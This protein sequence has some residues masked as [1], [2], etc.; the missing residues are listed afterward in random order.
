MHVENPF[1]RLVNKLV[2]NDDEN[3]H[4]TTATTLLCH[5]K[6]LRFPSAPA[7]DSY[8][9][10][11]VASSDTA[12][13]VEILAV[14]DISQ[15]RCKNEKTNCDDD[16]CDE[17]TNNVGNVNQYNRKSSKRLGKL[18]MSDGV[19][20]IVG[21]EYNRIPFIELLIQY[22]QEAN[23][24]SN[25][26]RPCGVL[27]RAV[28]HNSPLVVKGVVFLTEANIHLLSCVNVDTLRQQ[29]QV[30]LIEAN[31]QSVPSGLHFDGS[32]IAPLV[33]SPFSSLPSATPQKSLLQS[34]NA[35]NQFNS[36][37]TTCPPS[38]SASSAGQPPRTSINGAPGRVDPVVRE[39]RH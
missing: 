29:H 1:P 13:L 20:F 18:L 7:D 12:L 8:L 11:C 30:G 32:S 14:V 33:E 19:R 36:R 15:P 5:P 24:R 22:Q 9:H 37:Q 6:P 2:N 4:P 39:R 25:E 38:S 31:Q 35:A 27:G 3:T 28:L 26:A 21:I 34:D 16:E 10:S 23:R 17:T